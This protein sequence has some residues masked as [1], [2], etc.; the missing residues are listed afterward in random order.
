[1]TR[2]YDQWPPHAFRHK[3]LV[4]PLGVLKGKGAL[5]PLDPFG[6]FNKK[7]TSAQANTIN[8][9]PIPTPTAPITAA[10]A[11]VVSAQEQFA[12]QKLNQF[13]IGD[14]IYAGNTGG[15]KPG[16]AGYPGNPGA[17]PKT[18]KR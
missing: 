6:L 11:Q 1:M 13:T 18:F 14:T 7:G 10:N 12:K 4:D 2:L 3:S 8:A 5:A 15:F 9:L 17:G 16:E